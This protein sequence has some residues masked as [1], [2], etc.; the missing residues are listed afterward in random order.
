MVVS[1]IELLR[2][3]GHG[4][5]AAFHKLVD[6]HA[7]Y[8]FGV[9]CSLLGNSADA[10]D[11]IQETFAGAFRAAAKFRQQSSVKTWLL[12]ILVRQVARSRRSTF[13]VSRN[14]LSLHG[15]GAVDLPVVAEA[16]RVDHRLDVTQVMQS[17]SPEHREVLVLREFEHLSYEQ[18]AKTLGVPPGTV[19][20]RLY[21][22]RQELKQK[23]KGYHPHEL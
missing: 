9:A 10:E 23:L 14:A 3:T 22:A 7:G 12:Q 6:R 17:L 13:R 4:D 20:S 2:R 1:D 11:V 16:E 15:G 19:E 8:L 18:I 21:R 5:G